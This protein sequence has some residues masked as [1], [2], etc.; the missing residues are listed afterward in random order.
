M[1]RIRFSKSVLVAALCF[2]AL[3][4]SLHAILPPPS[5]GIATKT[6]RTPGLSPPVD[7][8]A[9]D[10]VSAL[11]GLDVQPGRAFRDTRT[12][13]WGTIILSQ[14]L[15]SGPDSA[16]AGAALYQF[17]ADHAADLAVDPAELQAS[18]RVTV[19]DGGA[20]VQIHARR[21]VSG[22][23]VRDAELSAVVNRGNL[24]LF[25][26]R[27]WADAPDSV[28][29]SVPADVARA[30]LAAYL[31]PYAPSSY[32]R[33]PRLELVP[34]ASGDAL[35][36]RLVWV[37]TPRFRGS[38]G[39]WE[40]LVDAQTG[41]VLAFRDTNHYATRRSVVGAVLP[42]QND[43]SV[44]GGIEQEGFPMPFADLT[45]VGTGRKVTT[46]SGGNAPVCMDGP[47]YMQFEDRKSVV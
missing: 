8:R 9:A 3:G 15:L 46:D 16:A 45:E 25:G 12:G 42:V 11:S 34:F 40:G 43:N 23:L 32:L 35:S 10:D 29:P 1:I 5:E 24:V 41:E 14:P 27:N 4:A 37:F 36:Y 28:Q 26:T 19:H 6:L 21:V 22:I 30:A 47:M 2:A 13:R 20:L 17:V 33:A 44:P 38:Q 31:A 7:L 39:S 18:P